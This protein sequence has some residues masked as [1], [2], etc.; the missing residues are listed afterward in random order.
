[1]SV[2]QMTRLLHGHLQHATLQQ[3]GKLWYYVRGSH[4]IDTL[5]ELF[6]KD[7]PNV[8]EDEVIAFACHLGT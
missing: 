8:K 5:F 3:N 7:T 4:V 6:Y 2:P 1:M